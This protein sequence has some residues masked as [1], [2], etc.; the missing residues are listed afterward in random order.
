LRLLRRGASPADV[1]TACTLV[2]KGAQAEQIDVQMPFGTDV[3]F[4]DVRGVVGGHSWNARFTVSLYDGRW[5]I[6]V[7]EAA[8]SKPRSSTTRP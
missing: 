6:A 7:G 4:A 2:P 8:D 1:E 3:A 5:Y